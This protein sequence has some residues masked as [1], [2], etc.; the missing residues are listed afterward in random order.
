MKVLPDINPA[1]VE[2]PVANSFTLPQGL[3]GFRNYTRAELL[4]MPEH[5]PFLWL[6]LHGETDSVNFIVIE[7]AGLIPGYEPEL[8]DEDAS[9]LELADSSE[10]MVLNIVSLQNQ[11]PL[12]ATVNLVGPI[13][14]NRRTR[15]GRQLVLSNYSRY[16]AHHPLVEAA[17]PATAGSRV[18]A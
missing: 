15:L 6:K 9:G 4:Y 1:E 13:V 16:S 8:F 5:L 3:I 11:R 17:A 12:D 14:V 7:P 10:A 2:S 18:T